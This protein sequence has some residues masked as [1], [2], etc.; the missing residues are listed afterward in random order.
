M[1][2][3]IVYVEGSKVTG[4]EVVEANMLE[5][6]RRGL[7]GAEAVAYDRGCKQLGADVMALATKSAALVSA[8]EA[9]AEIATARGKQF[10][11]TDRLPDHKDLSDLVVEG[12]KLSVKKAA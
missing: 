11:L 12:G 7:K 6:A 10:I 1:S 4:Y 2:K 9:L 5:A 3:I 8:D